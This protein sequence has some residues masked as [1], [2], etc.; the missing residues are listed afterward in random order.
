MYLLQQLA[1]ALPVAALYAVLAFGYAIAFG[2][3]RRVDLTYGALFA[4]A[5]QIF[6]LFADVGWNRLWLVLPACLA[7]GA[8]CSLAY[9][10]GAGLLVGRVVM[11]PLLRVSPNAVI[12]AGLGVSLVLMETARLAAKTRS[13][14]LPPFLNTPVA[15]WSEGA[16]DVSLTLIQLGNIA[17]ML[18][19]V[20]LGALVLRFGRAGRL[21]RAVHDDP[22][23]AELC[24]VDARSVF[25][26]AYLVATLIACVS[27][28][29]ATSYYGN[30]DF[31]AGLLFGLKVV[32]IA[33]IG[34]AGHP[35]RAAA[36][37]ALLGLAETL[38]SAFGPMAW[39]DPFVLTLL[40]VIVVAGGRDRPVP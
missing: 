2:V 26:G 37:A 6:V 30:M 31:G 19:I 32:M 18:A 7:L 17:V 38:W 20:G 36:G 12:V 39:R 8:A 16:A 29:L 28:I 34:G 40:I 10:A 4:F 25:L 24:G 35:L 13:L 11:A 1:N 3:T 5:G 21:W 23:A 9:T 14:W 15:L 27:G 33:G 22:R